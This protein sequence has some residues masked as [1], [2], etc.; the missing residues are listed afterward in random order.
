MSKITT[1]IER[2]FCTRVKKKSF[3]LLTILMPFLFAALVFVPIWLGSMKDDSTRTLAIIDK[4][5][6]YLPA[7]M[8]DETFSIAVEP[9]MTEAL[10]SD[11]SGVEAVLLIT[12]DLRTHPE[13]V[14]L[15]SQRE[16]Q[17]DLMSFVTKT[18]NKSIRE[19]KLEAYQL[20]NL[21]TIIED[22]QSEV[23][24]KTV[25]WN[26]DGEETISSTD[27]AMM[28]GFL[29]TFLIYMF[30]MS[31]GAMV[32]QG[33]MEEKTNRIMEIMVSSVRP[34]ELMMGK[35]IGI[36]LVGIVQMLIWGI[37]LAIIITSCTYF[38][39]GEVTEAAT[40]SVAMGANPEALAP[41]TS[42]GN[43][44][45]AAL[46][47]LPYLEFA[48]MFLLCFIG[49]Y[50]LYASF[51]AAVGAAVNEQEDSSQFMMPVIIILIFG[52]YAAMGSIENTDGPLAFWTSLF[53]LTSPIVLMVRI[54]FGIPLWQEVLSIGILYTTAILF[55]WGAGRIYRVGIL[56]YGKKPTIKEML[57]WMRYR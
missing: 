32:M 4:T 50:L 14:T 28:A 21:D 34:F 22:V 26:K 16:V 30:V 41:A 8:H 31:Y 11:T 48:I 25:K 1:I 12:D 45:V 2:E 56:M 42:G 36:A 49:G 9:E 40:T 47:G 57:K 38:F 55:V 13:A 51:F 20:P 27:I 10:R 19:D 46:A 17:T 52:M 43:E 39:G 15:Y 7:F 37:M 54:P 53:P 29:F 33:V 24:I 23:S 18:I 3:I 35:I 44:L 6:H 5:G